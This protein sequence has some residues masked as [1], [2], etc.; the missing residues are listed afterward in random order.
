MVGPMDAKFVEL[1][2]ILPPLVACVVWDVVNENITLETIELADQV[3]GEEWENYEVVRC[4]A[5]GNP[6]F[7]PIQE[8]KVLVEMMLEE[9]N[10]SVV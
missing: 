8:A 4:V 7:P 1:L 6:D 3:A 9:F 10:F 2:K 5:A